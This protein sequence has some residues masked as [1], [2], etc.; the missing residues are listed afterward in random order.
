MS[1]EGCGGDNGILLLKWCDT[2]PCVPSLANSIGD[3]AVSGADQGQLLLH[4]GVCPG[5][6]GACP[7]DLNR[8]GAV[9]H[10]YSY[11]VASMCFGIAFRPGNADFEAFTD[12]GAWQSA[13]GSFTTIGF[14][15]FT[16][17]SVVTE[18]YAHFGIHF[19]D[20]TDVAIGPGCETFPKDCWGLKGH[21]LALP[22]EIRLAFDTPQRW[23]AVDFPGGIQIDLYRQGRQISDLLVF[24]QFE[25]GN[26]GGVIS[27]EAFDEAVIW[28][29]T[30]GAVFID[31]LHFGVPAPGVLPLLALGGVIGRARRRA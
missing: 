1:G 18:Q 13:V 20:G 16:Q 30:D 11:L 10:L 14:H 6:P 27:T 24:G 28:D 12:A 7:E 29:P 23:I 22:D 9:R 5:G 17:S 2:A 21:I 31:D 15:D 26:F 8:E 25:I 4:W 19:T 3:G